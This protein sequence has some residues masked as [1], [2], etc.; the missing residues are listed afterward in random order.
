MRFFK[1]L[2]YSSTCS[3]PMLCW[4]CLAVRPPDESGDSAP[5]PCPGLSTC[6]PAREISSEMRAAVWASHDA[7]GIDGAVSDKQRLPHFGIPPGRCCQ[8][9]CLLPW[10]LSHATD[11]EWFPSIPLN[12][13]ANF[14]WAWAHANQMFT[15]PH[16]HTHT[17]THYTSHATTQGYALSQWQHIFNSTH[18][19]HL[20]HQ[21]SLDE[22][23]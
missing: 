11:G 8:D 22:I 19:S 5:C 7:P 18:Q 23:K 3:Y 2:F 12:T 15:W 9:N 20:R 13:N 10:L 16:T 14:F 21:D 1:S 4:L 6:P 17:H